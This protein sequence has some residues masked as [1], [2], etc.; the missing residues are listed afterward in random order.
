MC[1]VLNT[2]DQGEGRGAPGGGREGGVDQGGRRGQER[3][4]GESTYEHVVRDGAIKQ[5]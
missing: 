5:D 2:N 3:Q 4:G 1:S